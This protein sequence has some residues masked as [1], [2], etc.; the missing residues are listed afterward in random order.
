LSYLGSL[1]VLFGT[2][3]ARFGFAIPPFAGDIIT[4]VLIVGSLVV[5]LP[6]LA[7]WMTMYH[8]R[9]AGER[10]GHEIVQRVAT[11]RSHAGT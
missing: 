10:D 9:M 1:L 7:I 6:P 11:W 4:I 3:E 2:L 8:R 5:L